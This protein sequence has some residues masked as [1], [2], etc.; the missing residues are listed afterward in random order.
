[1]DIAMQLLIF[2]LQLHVLIYFG[3]VN[4]S[5]IYN[6]CFTVIMCFTVNVCLTTVKRFTKKKKKNLQRRHVDILSAGF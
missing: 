4:V 5:S 2:D 1:M 3:N 6:V